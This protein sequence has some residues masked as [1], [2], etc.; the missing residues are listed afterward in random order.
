MAFY[1]IIH[2]KKV[3]ASYVD[4]ELTDY[5]SATVELTIGKQANRF[6]IT[7]PKPKPDLAQED[8]IIFYKSDTPLTTLSDDKIIFFGQIKPYKYKNDGKSEKVTVSGYD[9]TY[10]LLQKQEV[11]REQ[12]KTAPEIIDNILK[13]ISLSQDGTGTSGIDTSGIATTKSDG[14]SFPVIDNF[15][16][17]FENVYDV[18]LKLST[19]QYTGDTKTYLFYI[20]S[21]N[22]AHW[23]HPDDSSYL[24]G[25]TI[26][27]YSPNLLDQSFETSTEGIPGILVVDCGIGLSGSTVT[28]W[29][30][31][32]YVKSMTTRVTV[33]KNLARELW[34]LEKYIGNLVENSTGVFS[35]EKG[36]HYTAA[37]SYP[38]TTSWGETVEDDNDYISK[39]NQKLRDIG[40]IEA[41][42]IFGKFGTGYW[43][44]SLSFRDTTLS[45]GELVTV[46]F[47]KVHKL[48]ANKPLRISKV[49][50]SFG[51]NLFTT[52]ELIDD[53]YAQ[54]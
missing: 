18:I 45:Q 39:F 15:V 12:G 8:F 40:N 3:G 23:Y 29:A 22:V 38:F 36:T 43:K 37:K 54:W 35:D 41:Q 16:S 32:P 33:K 13:R 30:I 20:N 19:P 44:G 48:L 34:Y 14:N 27:P 4:T 42:K 51:K 10:L 50:I 11:V 2:R 1:K 25:V 46:K 21:N 47:P 28:T 6:E 17:N 9:Y 53:E 49:R 31:N 52:V 7:F 26:T 24:S 5:L